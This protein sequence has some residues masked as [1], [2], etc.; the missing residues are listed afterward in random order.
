M[1]RERIN[2]AVTC[3]STG[4]TTTSV[5]LP[6]ALPP[7]ARAD[8]DRA[9]PSLHGYDEL[10]RDELLHTRHTRQPD[11]EPLRRPSRL[12]IHGELA[13]LGY[14]IGASTVWN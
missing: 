8:T 13:G 5:A 10:L 2:G 14:Q 9:A 12:T 1:L 3:L 11:S 6:A 4:P 7:A